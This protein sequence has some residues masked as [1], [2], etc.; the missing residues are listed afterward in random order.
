M[1]AEV[2]VLDA[3][4]DTLQQAQAA[5]IEQPRHE[6][7][8]ARHGGEQPLDL[9][10]GEH[11]WRPSSRCCGQ[12]RSQRPGAYAGHPDRETPGR[13]GLAAGWRPTPG[14]RGK[15]EKKRFTSC[16]PSLFGWVLPPK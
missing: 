8:P 13:S 12:G 1:L 14:P 5:A 4:A 16:A 9:R 10:L 2:H 11:S 6:G 3:Q 7:V 15:V